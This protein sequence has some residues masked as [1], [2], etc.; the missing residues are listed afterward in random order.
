MSY[1]K[2]ERHIDKHVWRLPIPLYNPDD[3]LHTDIAHLARELS[4]GFADRAILTNNFVTTRRDFRDV[5]TT[6][7]TGRQLD[8]LVRQLLGEPPDHAGAGPVLLPSSGLL[9]VTSGPLSELS[10]R[11]VE[12]DIDIEYDNDRR[13]YLWGM[14]VS[15]SQSAAE[16]SHVGSADANFDEID[17][18][19]QFLAMITNVINTEAEAGHTIRIYHYGHVER[20]H[21]TRL[22]GI[23]AAAPLELAHDLLATIRAHFFSGTGYGLKKLA[24]LAGATWSEAGASGEQTYEWLAAARTGDSAAWARLTRYNE[25]D[26][27]ATAALRHY[28]V[29]DSVDVG[30]S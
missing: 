6:S 20:L 10:S 4:A 12:V 28:L 25:D 9:R 3:P 13:V 17:L 27:R 16:Y 5:I 14:L 7:D 19:R 1:G 22:L 2:D 23:D 24:P 11:D 8:Q 21:L 15:R 29:T 26:T 18:A 30:S